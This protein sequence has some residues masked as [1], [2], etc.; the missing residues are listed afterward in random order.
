MT[1]NMANCSTFIF[2][3]DGTVYSGNRLYPGAQ[4]LLQ[5]L[6]HKKNQIFFLSNNSTD[7]AET[8]RKKLMGMNITVHDSH[9]LVAAELAGDY[10]LE[11]YG[12]VRVKTFGTLAL[13][14][15]IKAAGHMILPVGRREQSDVVVIGR[16]PFFTYEKLYDCTRSLIE[17]AKL[18]AVN[19]D[20][21]HPGEDGSR[22]PETGALISA[23]QAV[24]GGSE[25][26]SVGKPSYFSFK[27]IFEQSSA[28]PESCIMIGDNPYTDIKGGYLAGMRTVWISHGQ[29]FPLDLGFKPDVTVSCIDELL[30]SISLGEVI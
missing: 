23:I 13:E 16:D 24:T 28:E 17:G 7:T 5:F 4:K 15:S 21:Y 19:P 6:C 30:P 29:T 10:L 3:L 26:E 12:R 18:V 14:H 1:L 2:D 27:K 22:V 9:I 25:V 11:K 8:I 20:K